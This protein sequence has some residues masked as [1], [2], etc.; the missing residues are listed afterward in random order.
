MSP[1]MMDQL[2]NAYLMLWETDPGLEDR[3]FYPTPADVVRMVDVLVSGERLV[4]VWDGS[5]E[6]IQMPEFNVEAQDGPVHR[7][8]SFCDAVNYDDTPV[9][10]INEL[11]EAYAEDLIKEITDRIANRNSIHTL[12]LSESGVKDAENASL[13]AA[14]LT[15]LMMDNPADGQAWFEPGSG[16]LH[17]ASQYARTFHYM[18]G[19]PGFCGTWVMLPHPTD[20]LQVVIAYGDYVTQFTENNIHYLSDGEWASASE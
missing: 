12:E 11:R 20:P 7:M 18:N 13:L 14:K 8:H 2:I 9:A 10:R 3:D 5:P 1:V 15:D 19:C 16:R 4:I 17:Y 6:Y